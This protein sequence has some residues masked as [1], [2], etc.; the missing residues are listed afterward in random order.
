MKKGDTLTIAH[1]ILSLSG[2]I[3]F[4]KDVKIKVRE[5]VKSGGFYGKVSGYWI[6]ERIDGV[7]L[8][9]HSGIWFLT[10]FKM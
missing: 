6:D 5:V 7:K 2:E 8:Q 1:D 9:G 3:I 4:K 10:C